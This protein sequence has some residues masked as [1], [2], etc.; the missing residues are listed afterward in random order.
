[1]AVTM[2]PAKSGSPTAFLTADIT[3]ISDSI[4]FDADVLPDAPNMATLGTG[5]TSEV[6][7]YTTKTGTTIS[8]L[9]R[10]FSGTTAQTWPIGTAVS[11]RYTSYDHDAFRQN[12]ENK[13]IDGG[14]L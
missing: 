10:G 7:L 14:T 2:Y 9:T 13:D 11:R 12:L 3:P 4:S 6:V 8:G 1:M 5:A